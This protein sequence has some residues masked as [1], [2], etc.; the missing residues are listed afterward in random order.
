[1][2]ELRFSPKH[3]AFILARRGKM[4]AAEIGHKIG[5]SAD[6]VKRRWRILGQTATKPATAAEKRARQSV[7][8]TDAE[9]VQL[10][11]ARRGVTVCPPAAACGI[12]PL[13]THMGVTA[14]P[15]ASVSYREK[16]HQ[17]VTAAKRRAA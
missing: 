12:T 13:E 7:G 3:D 11:L 5:R 8:K 16:M 9:L 1:M 10:H 4:T 6:A 14:Q 15:E 17:L 2:S